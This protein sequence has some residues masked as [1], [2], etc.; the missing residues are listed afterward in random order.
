MS[1]DDQM[2]SLF[3]T[4]LEVLRDSSTPL[5]RPQ[6]MAEVER[7]T[8]STETAADQNPGRPARW[9]VQL[10]FRTSEAATIGWLTKRDG[11]AITEAGLQALTEH[12]GADLFHELSRLHQQHRAS[13]TTASR[14]PDPRWATI[15]DAIS[16]LEPGMWTSYGELS[17]LTGLSAQ[18]IGRFTAEEGSVPGYRV[19][20]ADGSI[21]GD[22]RWTTPERAD[23]PRAVLE[24]EGVEFDRQGRADSDQKVTAA[25]FRE[26]LATRAPEPP[27][28]RAWLVRGSS[29]DGND[30]IPVWLVRGTTSLAA[31]SLRPITTPIPLDE[32]RA[33]VDADYQ[34]KSYAAREMKV[35]EFDGFCNRMRIGDWVLTTSQGKTYFGRVAGPAD[36]TGSSDGRSNLRREVQWLNATR[37]VPFNRLPQPL[38]AKLASQSDV[39]ELTADI[40]AVERLLGVLD[41]VVDE[42]A[43]AETKELTFPEITDELAEKTLLVE[44]EWLKRQVDDLWDRKQMIFYGPPGTGKTY[45]AR[46]L[47]AHLA[48]P[49]AVKLVQF[50]PSYTYEDFFEGFRPVERKDGQLAFKLRSGPFRTLVEAA[51][52]RPSE[53]HI[54]IIDEI[55]RAN[56]AKVFGELYF[57]LEYRDQAISLMYSQEEGFTLPPNVFVIGTMNTTDRTIALLDAAM[58]RRFAF[59]ELHPSLP[60]T[61]RMLAEWLRRLKDEDE[62][63]VA[64]NLDAPELLDALNARIEDRDMAIGPS[65]LMRPEIYRRPDGLARVWETSILPL[66]AEHH[67]GAPPGTLDR[68]RLDVLRS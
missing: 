49:S 23:S 22:F 53:P 35:A 28:R 24:R 5:P 38:P 47:A 42:P 21:A 13:R 15:S 48:D 62:E 39:V 19:L 66:L 68:Y 12:R 18:S 41:I 11:W 40:A 3:R 34:H 36:Y 30:L 16:L 9:Q 58:R 56:I 43:P 54:L 20:R 46:G 4:A 60:P 6:V 8:S 10:G 31:T 17:D 37:P 51:R 55:N 32:L 33:A 2:A 26:I 44:P 50:H 29:V 57:L 65:F 61:S 52:Q 64:H 45:L 59:V 25:D 1:Y 67:Y 7:R 14:W 63:G 27:T